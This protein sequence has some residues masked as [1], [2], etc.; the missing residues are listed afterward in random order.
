MLLGSGGLLVAQVAAQARLVDQWWVGPQEQL[1]DLEKQMA[2]GQYQL[3]ATGLDNVQLSLEATL[4]AGI[5]WRTDGNGY[6]ARMNT[7]LPYSLYAAALGKGE[8]VS[9]ASALVPGPRPVG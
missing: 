9:A 6:C 1:V 7:V 8:S 3:Q 2:M 5:L 4:L